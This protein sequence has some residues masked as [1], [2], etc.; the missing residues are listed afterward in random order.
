MLDGAGVQAGNVR[1]ID[2][3]AWNVLR[4]MRFLPF[5][6]RA[7]LCDLDGV[8]VDSGTAIE[9]AWIRFAS[10]HGLDSEQLLANSHGRRSV[11]LIRLVA[12]HLDAEAEAAQVE[13]DEVA[14]A[15]S[16]EALPGARE[17]VQRVPEDRLAIVTSGSRRLAVARI[18]A[19][20][21][22]VPDVLVTAEDV[23]SGKP[24]PAGY[25]RAAAHLGVEPEHS[26]VIEDAPAGVEAGLAAGMNVIAVLTTNDEFTLRRAHRRI[27]DLSELLPVS[28]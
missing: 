16:I 25:L 11:D 6:P 18:R 15:E 24:D 9:D 12:P 7:L 28:A 14:T 8:L 1:G 3:V 13:Q 5:E 23:E 10:R 22:P 21:L 27:A 26:L 4:V 2:T 19:A 20:G 17:L